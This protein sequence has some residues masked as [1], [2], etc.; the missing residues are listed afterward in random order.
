MIAAA[1]SAAC[2]VDREGLR[3]S[4]TAASNS[5]LPGTGRACQSFPLAPSEAIASRSAGGAG[6]AT[7]GADCAPGD[8]QRGDCAAMGSSRSA[9]LC[10]SD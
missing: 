9:K 7:I 2:P 6:M 3:A 4:I 8:V 5:A 10:S 1:S